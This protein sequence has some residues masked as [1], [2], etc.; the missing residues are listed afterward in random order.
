VNLR[1]RYG[2]LIVSRD[3]DIATY[4]SRDGKVTLH[5]PANERIRAQSGLV[6]IHN[7]TGDWNERPLTGKR[8]LFSKYSEQEFRI[9]GRTFCT[10]DERD[11]LAVFRRSTSMKKA[12]FL[13][14]INT[15]LG[16]VEGDE[17]SGNDL[18]ALA[19]EVTSLAEDEIGVED[20]D[21]DEEEKDEE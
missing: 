2:I 14:V 3:L 4:T 8:I 11:V 21:E 5:M 18:T 19:E 1:P 20:P 12:T 15:Q 9:G 7:E 10:V 16:L 13:D 17:L 6:H